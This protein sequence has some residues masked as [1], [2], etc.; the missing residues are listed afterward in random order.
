MDASR[1]ERRGDEPIQ[2]GEI[3]EPL[4]EVC[5]GASADRG[6]GDT[7]ISFLRDGHSQD[8]IPEG[9]GAPSERSSGCRFQREFPARPPRTRSFQKHLIPPGSG[10]SITCTRGKAT[11]LS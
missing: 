7:G 9:G 2:R 6:D 11:C 5:P 3:P 4:P 10:S 1:P 8:R